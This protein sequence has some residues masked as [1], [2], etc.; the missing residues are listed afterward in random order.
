M[1]VEFS[2]DSNAGQVKFAF[3]QKQGIIAI[4]AINSQ[5][6]SIICQTK[7]CSDLENAMEQA[8]LLVN[9]QQNKLFWHPV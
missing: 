5:P 9:N 2:V 4:V 6:R 3:D 1:A 8:T 7:S